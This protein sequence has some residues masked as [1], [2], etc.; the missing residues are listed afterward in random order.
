MSRA[1]LGAVCLAGL[2]S[3][4]A[5]DAIPMRETVDPALSSARFE[6]GL[7]LSGLVHGSFRQI[8]G[9]L[10]PDGRRWRV[11]V[12][13]DA[14]ELELDGPGWMERSTRSR[15]F[16]DVDRHPQIRFISAPFTRA[17]LR[18][19]GP[20]EGELHLRG[21]V[22][23][24]AFTLSPARCPRPGHGCDI[25]VSGMISRRDFGM[26]SQRMWLRDEVGFDFRVRLA[27]APP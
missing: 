9:E 12:R 4:A 16:L 3:A 26:T 20:L 11:Q 23:P 27:E 17:L 8:E 14:R 15:S 1:W 25:R 21:R 5:S 24:V 19:G 22:R 18:S 2:V 13:V 6:V 10:E 7:R